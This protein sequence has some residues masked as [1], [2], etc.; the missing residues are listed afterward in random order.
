MINNE[1]IIHYTETTQGHNNALKVL[2]SKD[3]DN[4]GLPMFSIYENAS[5][6]WSMFI[7]GD[8]QLVPADTLK[9]ALMI[10]ILLKNSL[11][12]S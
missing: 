12:L 2:K 5:G 1:Q 6:T 8:S 10:M 7:A 3:M 9:D 4:D 11:D